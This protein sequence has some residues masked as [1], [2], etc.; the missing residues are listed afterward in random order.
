[1]NK[2]EKKLQAARAEKADRD[3]A[4]S[5]LIGRGEM[6]YKHLHDLDGSLAQLESGQHNLGERTL[7]MNLSKLG[8]HNSKAVRHGLMWVVQ[9]LL[10]LLE[11]RR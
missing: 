7:N 4:I 11:E 10:L 3:A 8:K 1:M 9:A 2:V 5:T 6:I